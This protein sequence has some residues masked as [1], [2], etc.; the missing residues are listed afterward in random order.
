MQTNNFSRLVMNPAIGAFGLAKVAKT[1][2]EFCSSHPGTPLVSVG[3][4][5]GLLERSV[6]QDV[7]NPIFM[8]DPEPSGY[9]P[10]LEKPCYYAAVVKECGMHT[11]H[12]SVQE[13]VNDYPSLI[14]GQ[15]LLLLNWCGWGFED[16]YDIE[17]VAAL[18]PRSILVVY[19][20]TGSAGSPAFHTFLKKQ[21]MY[22]E[23]YVYNIVDPRVE[24]EA[25]A[26]TPIC[27]IWLELNDPSLPETIVEDVR[28]MLPHNAT[29]PANKYLLEN[30]FALER[31]SN[32]DFIKD[33]ISIGCDRERL[34][35]TVTDPRKMGKMM[36]DLDFMI[37][38]L[39]KHEG[40]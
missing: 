18:K 2:R 16:I 25:C 33:F 7:E 39:K 12:K 26:H 15:S 9:Y 37:K 32:P 23:R 19:E 36:S 22:Q 38:A 10:G 13:L 27:M 21:K 35:E 31:Q 3:C 4:G 14:D 1:L 34:E 28:C 30:E 6:A 29:N 17:A 20:K 8:V 11:T 40:K 24:R 5:I